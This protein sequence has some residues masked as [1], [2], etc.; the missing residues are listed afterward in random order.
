M[1]T[2]SR[3]TKGGNYICKVGYYDIRQK[4]TTRKTKNGFGVETAKS[5]FVIYHGNKL[6]ESGFNNK[7]KAISKAKEL[8]G[9]KY[10]NI[11]NLI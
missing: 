7:D 10:R 8:L 1:A 6:V 11:Y 4:N 3:A 5:E 9:E 2:K